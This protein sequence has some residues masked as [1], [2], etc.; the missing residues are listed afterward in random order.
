MEAGNFAPDD[1]QMTKALEKLIE[2]V[3]CVGHQLLQ[4]KDRKAA[5]IAAT[6]LR[7]LRAR[8]ASELPR[9]WQPSADTSLEREVRR[10]FNLEFQ[11]D[12]P[13]WTDLLAT[14]DQ[15]MVADPLI[16]AYLSQAQPKT[17]PTKSAT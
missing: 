5:F 6:L 15:A 13:Q 16:A 7:Y 12:D 1:A 3:D 17:D 11:P 14:L 10:L 2:T 8:H 4:R 9:R